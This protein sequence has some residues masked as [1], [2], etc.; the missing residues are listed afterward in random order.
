MVTIVQA[1][2]PLQMATA[3]Q[4]MREYAAALGIEQSL[5][6]FEEE[7]QTLPGKYAP[8]AG[9]ILLA[10]WGGEAAG[11]VALRPFEGDGAC[12]MKRLFVRAR[13]WGKSVG[14]ALVRKLIAEAESI[15]YQKMRL[16]TMPGRMDNAIALYRALGFRPIPA[17]VPSPGDE[18]IFMELDLSQRRP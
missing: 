14:Q 7:M 13:F 12:E 18:L 3:R 16:D 10:Y 6:G 1:E 5:K 17:Y 11:V 8:P 9:R 4:L 15:P 2:T